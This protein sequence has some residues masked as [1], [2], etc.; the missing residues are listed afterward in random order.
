MLLNRLI[1]KSVPLGLILLL[2]IFAGC[3]RSVRLYPILDTDIYVKDNG[4]VCMTDRYMKEV[5]QI[6]IKEM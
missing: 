6:K 1:K 2:T 4:D 5:L 3:S